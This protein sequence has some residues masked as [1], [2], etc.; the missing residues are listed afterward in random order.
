MK[1][2][3]LRQ[4]PLLLLG[5]I[6]FCVQIPGLLSSIISVPLPSTSESLPR[7]DRQI[8]GSGTAPPNRESLA[9]G[10][11]SASSVPSGA[12]REQPSDDLLD[13]G[14]DIRHSLSRLN[15][16]QL[17]RPQ[18]EIRSSTNYDLDA[19]FVGGSDSLVAK[20]VG[21][22][23]GTRTPDGDYTSAYRGHTDPGNGVWNLGTF[24]YQHGASS[25]QEADRK[26]LRRLREQVSA[27]QRRATRAGITL[28]LTEILNGIDLAN[29]SPLAALGEPG[30]AEWM[31]EAYRQGLRGEE[32]ILWARVMGY[33]DVRRDRWNAPGLG[34]T[35]PLIR[36]DQ[37]RRME[38]I[39]NA[40]AAHDNLADIL[41]VSAAAEFSPEALQPLPPEEDS[42][43][44][45]FTRESQNDGALS[46]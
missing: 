10:G 46:F 38:A 2:V 36:R 43:T 13:F 4:S 39:A 26:Q 16:I 19:L 14:L 30:Y 20:A 37:A 32:A 18:P 28:G 6:L 21:G 31:A 40:I 24:S 1:H 35:E 15:P 34:N 22:A 8:T 33:W 45:S 27:M 44:P 29:Q 41:D 42:Q 11:V 3:A 12:K 5:T 17:L 9:A 25:P 7:L 23:E